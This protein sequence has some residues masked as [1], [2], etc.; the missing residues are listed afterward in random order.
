M[1]G[2]TVMAEPFMINSGWLRHG[3]IWCRLD[4]GP[5]ETREN[6]VVTGAQALC[7]EDAVRSYL[8]GLTLSDENLTLRWDF[9]LTNGPLKRCPGQ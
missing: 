6:D 1:E 8:L 9:T 2:G 3:Q 7:G 4:W 5:L